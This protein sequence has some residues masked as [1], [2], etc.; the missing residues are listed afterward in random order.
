VLTYPTGECRGHY[1]PIHLLSVA[2]ETR[3]LFSI[4][5]GGTVKIWELAEQHCLL[6]VLSKTHAIPAQIDGLG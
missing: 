6:T 4:D 3:Q 1:A 2:E 5:T